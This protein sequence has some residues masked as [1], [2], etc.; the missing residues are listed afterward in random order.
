[1]IREAIN[2]HDAFKGSAYSIYAKGSYANNT[3]V[4]SD[5][6]VDIGAWRTHVGEA[7]NYRDARSVMKDSRLEQATAKTV[8]AGEAD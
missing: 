6:D 7:S 1:M 4:K 3:N 5:S 2:A 8:P